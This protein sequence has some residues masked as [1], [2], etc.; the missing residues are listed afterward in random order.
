MKKLLK[1]LAYIVLTLIVLFVLATF[2]ATYFIKPN[3]Y[4]NKIAGLVHEETGRD[5][6]IQGDIK[7][8]FFPWLGVRVEDA[9]LSNAKGFE[10]AQFIHVGE[11]DI[12]VKLIPLLSRQVELGRITLKDLELNLAKN[13]QGETN[14]DD[15]EKTP[16]SETEKPAAPTQ[17]TA[18]T[19]ASTSTPPK[20]GGLALLTIAGMDVENATISWVDAQKDRAVKLTK[21]NIRGDNAAIGKPFPFKLDLDIDS[22]NPDLRGHFTL[23][24]D[25][26]LGNDYAVYQLNN[27]RTTFLPAEKG[28]TEFSL[29]AERTLL[30]V[31]AQTL[32]LSKGVL[33]HAD[34]K[35]DISVEGQ[36][37]L[38][39][40]SFQG[41]FKAA[42]FNLKSALAQLGH[43][44]TTQDPSALEKVGL[45]TRFMAT[46]SSIRLEPL[47]LQ[48]D[49]SYIAGRLAVTDFAKNAV[50]FDLK[51]D[52]LNVDRYL[53]KSEST[54]QPAP[55]AYAKATAR[56]ASPSVAENPPA[57]SQ[58]SSEALPLPPVNLNG[59]LTVG[60]LTISQTDLDHVSARV[61]SQEG[62]MKLDPLAAG[63]YRGNVRG[64]VTSDFRVAQPKHTIKAMLSNIDMTQLIKSGRV[65]GR[66]TVE[67]DLTLQGKNKEDIL[68]SLNGNVH[69]TVQQGALMGANIP[70][71]VER[72]IA[73]FKRQSL[74]AE[75]AQ[76]DRTPFDTLKG[77]G[78]FNAGI[79]SNNDLLIQS[80]E[81]KGTG[82]GTMNLVNETL[83]Y[84]LKLVGLHTVTSGGKSTVEERQTAIPVAITGTFSKPI[85]TPDLKVLLQGDLDKKAVQTIEEKF[86]RDAGRAAGGLIKL[87]Q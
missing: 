26:V 78:V 81:L 60:K 1:T 23:S 29:Q 70:Y 69:F 21:V 72:A 51:I 25:V 62:V 67:T 32:S 74:P 86:G 55:S 84:R 41:S 75:P 34:L 83:D 10:P 48:L 2:L 22:K 9:Q 19:T 13:K 27:F 65:L 7:L 46:D 71:E 77:T 47:A 30:N 18:P 20:K 15:I 57:S 82:G 43:P 76:K 64:S 79:F 40:P 49:G 17:P 87:L 4:K 36:K 56:P 28:A 54:S 31:K 80:S 52:Q 3:S 68:R 85:I 39:K 59:N 6:V 53:P 33:S 61:V 16:A 63:V 44:M 8:S 38:D 37:I 66:A 50:Q 12:R 24:S 45:E 11:A 5:L 42:T 14:W 73:L 58:A 35:A